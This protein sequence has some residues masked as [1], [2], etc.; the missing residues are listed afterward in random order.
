MLRFS[1]TNGTVLEITLDLTQLTVTQ[2]WPKSGERQEVKIPLPDL[3]EIVGRV[4]QLAR[5]FV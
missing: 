3:R 1:L 5:F 4:R 2:L